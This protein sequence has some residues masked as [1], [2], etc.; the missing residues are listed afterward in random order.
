MEELEFFLWAQANKPPICPFRL[1][2]WWVQRMGCGG[3]CNQ[4][5][6]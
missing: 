4:H 6:W 5:E 2:W 1:W 3:K